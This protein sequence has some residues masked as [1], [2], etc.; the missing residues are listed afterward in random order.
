MAP[1]GPKEGENSQA[2]KEHL[3][4]RPTA[5]PTGLWEK[6]QPGVTAARATCTARIGRRALGSLRDVAPEGTHQGRC[7][8]QTHLPLHPHFESGLGLGLPRSA[9]C[10]LVNEGAYQ[11]LVPHRAPPPSVGGLEA[12]GFS[13][14]LLGWEEFQSD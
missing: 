7:H 5:G 8:L 4:R 14:L 1:L 13:H 3:F 12:G 10:Y 6:R 11:A 9:D 2:D